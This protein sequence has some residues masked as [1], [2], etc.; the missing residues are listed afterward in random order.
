M[1]LQAPPSGDMNQRVKL[2]SKSVSRG[3]NGEEVVTWVDVATLWAQVQQL[4]GKEFF[5]GAQMQDE[6]DVR[7][8]LRYRTAV[9]RDQ[10]LLWNGAPLDIVSIIVIGYK[11]ALELLCLSGVRNG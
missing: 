7:V 10:R 5:A 8:R 9:T 11:E 6:V 1:R 3:S 4:R 2:Q